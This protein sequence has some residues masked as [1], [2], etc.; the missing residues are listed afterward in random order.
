V[1]AKC[2]FPKDESDFSPS[3][4]QKNSGRCRLCVKEYNTLFYQKNSDKVK[5]NASQYRSENKELIKEN[6]Q[7]YYTENKDSIRISQ[8]EYYDNNVDNISKQKKQYRHTNK[9]KIRTSHR[10]YERKKL[11]LDI[12]FRLRKGVAKYVRDAI[13]RIGSIKNGGSIL[14]YLPYSIDE[15]KQHL[16]SQFDDKMNWD[17][18]G[19]YW[20]IDHIIPQSKLLYSSMTDDNF[21]KC[22]TLDN[23]RPLEAI[24]NIKKSNKIM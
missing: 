9:D 13:K 21:Q 5:V 10:E 12:S 11:K 20:H 4:F 6:K 14:D 22:W 8:K 7:I 19:S 2:N 3:E 15:L 1:C 23:L 16:E 18:Y 17:N 24:E